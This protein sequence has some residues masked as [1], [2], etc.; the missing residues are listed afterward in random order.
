MNKIIFPERA[1]KLIEFKSIVPKFDTLIKT[2]IAFANASGGKLIIGVDDISHEVI[3]I[4]D[5]DRTRIYDDFPNS[6][7]DSTN[8]SLIAQI[9]EQNFGEHSVL[10][11][12]IPTSSRKPYFLR[13]KGVNNGTYIRVG[14]STR[15]ATQE[16][17]DDLTRESQRISYDEEIVHQDISILSKEYL[18]SFLGARITTKR[19]LAERIIA[20]KPANSESYCPTVAGTL[21]FAETPENYIAEALV[22]CTKFNGTE[23]RDII[24]TEDITGPVDF[25]ASTSLKIISK[26]ISTNYSLQGEKLKQNLPIPIEALREAILNALLH[27]KYNIPG[28]TKIAVYEDR[29]EIFSPGCFPGLVDINNL[30]DGTTFLRNPILVRLAYQLNLIETR[31]TGIK[32]IYESCKKAR[33]KKPTY[34]EDGDFVKVIFYFEADI[35]ANINEEDAILE[36]ITQHNSI[37][38]QQLANYLSVSHNTALRKL[39]NL[40]GEKKL[41]KIGRGPAVRYIMV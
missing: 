18:H 26:W 8:P 29:V 22:R 40:I 28:A 16:Y 31:G 32:L 34:H 11:I 35:L 1:S 3:G 12:E 14:S 5:A 30:G 39:S 19:L 10:I 17:I 9:Y 2:C 7:Y 20:M 23:G 13:S 38:A 6:L 27:R 33:I 37:T 25:Q 36:F 24:Q 21:M 4:S 15:K 41:K